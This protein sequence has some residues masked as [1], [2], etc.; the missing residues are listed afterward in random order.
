MTTSPATIPRPARAA[1]RARTTA[2]PVLTPTRTAASRPGSASFSSAIASR[3]RRPARTARSGV[4]LVRDRRAEDRHD[5]V[6]DELLDR[7]AVALDLRA[8]RARGTGEIRRGRPRGRRCSERAVNPTRSQ[9]RTVTTLRSSASGIAARR[10]G[11]RSSG[12]TWHA[13]GSPDCKPDSAP[14]RVE[15]RADPARV[16]RSGR[17]RAENAVGSSY[18]S[19]TPGAWGGDPIA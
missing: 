15:S 14:R 1:R 18:G 10:A 13:R 19:R 2:S 6:A 16:R 17:G 8:Q 5:G 3:M 9:N 7:P 12:R 11:R 4:V